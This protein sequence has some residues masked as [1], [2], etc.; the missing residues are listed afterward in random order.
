MSYL[1]TNGE[2][3]ALSTKILSF[4]N[5]KKFL[6]N[7]KEGN[8]DKDAIV[9]EDKGNVENLEMKYVTSFETTLKS[10]SSPFSPYIA[11]S[12]LE[13]RIVYYNSEELRS[14]L[15][16]GSKKTR[17]DEIEILSETELDE[18]ATPGSFSI[19][20]KEHKSQTTS[21][22]EKG[23]EKKGLPHHRVA[24]N[25]LEMNPNHLLDGV[26]K[27]NDLVHSMLASGNYLGI[28]RVAY[29]YKP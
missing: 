19:N 10:T 15:I 8:K 21:K 7:L 27:Q 9:T 2:G 24:I 17:N 4:Q 29:F 11:S 16:Y 28:L 12:D 13:G 3:P 6:Q 14:N 26:K 18:K 1:L 22:N 23:D 5:I 25:A 20:Y